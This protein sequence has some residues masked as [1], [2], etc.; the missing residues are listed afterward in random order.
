MELRSIDRGR[1]IIKINIHIGC[2]D[3]QLI[4]ILHHC[5]ICHPYLTFAGWGLAER[6]LTIVH[7]QQSLL[8]KICVPY[9]DNSILE[10]KQIPLSVLNCSL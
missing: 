10:L 3:R 5:C 1:H 4:N 9:S 8:N 2:T 7:M 6:L